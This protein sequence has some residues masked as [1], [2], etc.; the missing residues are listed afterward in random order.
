MNR[1]G[2]LIVARKELREISINRGSWISALFLALFFAFTNMANLVAQGGQGTV[3]L[4]GPLV[5]LSMFIGVFTGFI[6]AGAVFYREKQSGV[7]ET[8]L[9]TPLN[10]RTIW[11]GKV[12]GVA[13]PAYLMALVAVGVLAAFTLSSGAAVQSV[14]PFTVLHVAL[15]APLFAAAAIGLVGYVQLALGMRENRFINFGVFTLLI[16]G[17]TVSSSLISFNLNLLG[18]VVLAILAASAGLLALA[19]YLSGRLKKEKIITTIPD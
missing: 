4:D 15:A 19:Y 1:E 13:V 5:Y 10:L 17:L 2:V 16:L 18:S 3:V 7:I 14:Q 6:L 9:C 12:I 11:L 8:L